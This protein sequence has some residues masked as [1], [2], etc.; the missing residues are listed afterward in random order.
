MSV[1]EK[2]F[3]AVLC[4]LLLLTDANM[5]DKEEDQCGSE[6]SC[7]TH[8]NDWIG[9]YALVATAVMYCVMSKFCVNKQ[10]T[11]KLN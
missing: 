3:V 11:S 10:K 7:M 4:D 8:F 1:S 5:L 9:V 2:L 6:Y